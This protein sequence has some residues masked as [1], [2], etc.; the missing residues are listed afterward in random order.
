M[1][2]LLFRL[3][4]ISMS[5]CHWSTTNK[6]SY[7]G[8][9]NQC[10]LPIRWMWIKSSDEAFQEAETCSGSCF[11]LYRTWCPESTRHNYWDMNKEWLAL[12]STFFANISKNT[13]LFVLTQL[14]LIIHMERKQAFKVKAVHWMMAIVDQSQKHFRHSAELLLEH[15][16]DFFAQSSE[17]GL[18]WK[19]S[20]MERWQSLYSLQELVLHFNRNNSMERILGND[21]IIQ[22]SSGWISSNWSTVCHWCV[23]RSDAYS[24]RNCFN[25]SV[26]DW[27]PS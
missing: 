8:A 9:H 6:N 2:Q 22:D 19:S 24:R 25:Q 15:L 27:F 20:W 26:L 17:Q 3:P 14:N 16:E 23:S 21:K 12:K 10:T 18:C 13:L 7:H 1:G 4:S 11:S 5:F